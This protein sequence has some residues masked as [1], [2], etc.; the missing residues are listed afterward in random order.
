MVRTRLMTELPKRGSVH[1]MDN[2]AYHLQISAQTA[3]RIALAWGKLVRK[4]CEMC[5][6]QGQ[7]HHDSYYPNRWLDVRWLCGRHHRAWHDTH[8]AEWPTIF[9][10]HPS[11]RKASRI[12]HGG[13]PAWPWFRTARNA[14]YVQRNGKQIFLGRDRE[15]A[16]RKFQRLRDGEPDLDAPTPENPPPSSPPVA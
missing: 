1:G 6:N 13:A 16:I 4:A 3:V 15:E 7:A 10:Y 8:E 5:D 2:R 9:E 11:D 12:N 14:W